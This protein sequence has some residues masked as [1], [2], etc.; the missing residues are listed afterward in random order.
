MISE[1]LTCHM[2]LEIRLDGKQLPFPIDLSRVGDRGLF[3]IE[4]FSF[5]FIMFYLTNALRALCVRSS[6]LESLDSSLITTEIVWVQLPCGSVRGS[7]FGLAGP[8][9]H[10]QRANVCC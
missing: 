4:S 1:Q 7:F 3:L 2:S 6:S 9:Y 10:H 8:R 5:D